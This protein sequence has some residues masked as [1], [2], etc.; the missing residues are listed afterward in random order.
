MITEEQGQF[1]KRKH[2]FVSGYHSYTT[3]AVRLVDLVLL[4]LSGWLA[5]WLRFDAWV[6]TER[7]LWGVTLGGLFSL[8]VLPS[9]NIYRSWR[10]QLRVRLVLKLLGA[11]AMIGGLLAFV[12]FITKTGANFSRLWVGFWMLFGLGG[13]ISIRAIAYPILNH[14]RAKGGNRKSVMLIGD[15]VSCARARRHILNLP[16]AGFDVG[17][18][19]L[20]EMDCN[21]ALDGVSHGQF[22]QGSSIDQDEEEVWICLPMTQ[23]DMVREIQHS[24]NLS[25]ANVRYMPD[26]RD[27]QLINHSFS[28]VAGLYMLDLSC[29]P[30]SLGARLVKRLEDR[31]L[32]MIILFFISPLLIM[33]AIGVKVT[34]AGPVLYRQERVGMNGKPFMMLKFRSMPVDVEKNGVRW[35]GAAS[36]PVTRFGSFIRRMSFD[37]LPQFINVLKGDMSIVGPRPER[38]VFVDQ[39]KHEIPGYMQKH[40]VKAGIT[41]WAQINGWRGDTDLQKRIEFDLWYVENW[42]LWLDLKI[43]FLTF[44]KGFIH[45]NA[46]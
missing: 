38:T 8:M 41:G 33:I 10:G 16:T 43:I 31:L 37:E 21:N 40:M 46:C 19:I 25:T 44:F 7:Y 32:S 42:S 34:S 17:R 39:L 36:M 24:L 29:T 1:M 11:Y 26:M 5:Y 20:T 6:M 12:M 14:I 28:D 18:I 3:D 9:F 15:P 4:F 45:K 22:Q 23:G 30:M 13:S 35:G 27:F 2:K